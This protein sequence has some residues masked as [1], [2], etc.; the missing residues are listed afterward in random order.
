MKKFNKRSRSIKK[1]RDFTLNE[2][3]F[4]IQPA[5]KQ[6]LKNMFQIAIKAQQQLFQKEKKK[7]TLN[8]MYNIQI[9][10]RANTNVKSR[11]KVKYLA[12]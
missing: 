10:K 7:K 11:N 6:D 2:Q 1:V 3:N 5:F 4:M 8:S 9:K 12:V